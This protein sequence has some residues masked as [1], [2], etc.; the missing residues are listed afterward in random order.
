MD[1]LIFK[2]SRLVVPHTLRSEMIRKIH[3][4]HM[5]IIKC[6]ERKAQIKIASDK[7]IVAASSL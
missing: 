5:G 2:N 3:E 6:N 1:E 4:S 7:D